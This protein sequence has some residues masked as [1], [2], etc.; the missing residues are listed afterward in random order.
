LHP[1]LL[2][3]KARCN[4]TTEETISEPLE[5]VEK[6]LELA[7]GLDKSYFPALVE[8]AYFQLNVMDNAESAL[9]L[10][11][12]AIEIING[13]TTKAILGKARC[14]AELKAEED[15]LVYIEQA[16]KD[17]IE[18]DKMREFL[19]DVYIYSRD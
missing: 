19:D 11:D 9:P 7:I 14:I 2:N 18:A 6:S 1:E 15:A 16:K 5:D 12:K 8:L 10:F 3:L 17:I 4:Q 13:I